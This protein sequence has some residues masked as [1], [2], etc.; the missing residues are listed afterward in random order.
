MPWKICLT[1]STNPPKKICF[2]LPVLLPKRRLPV[3]PPPDP[4][5]WLDDS[6]I[7]ETTFKDLATLNMI[8]VM[9]A[10]LT[11]AARKQVQGVVETNIKEVKLPAEY[12]LQFV[13]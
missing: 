2:Y 6:R 9:A 13:E 8:S 1:L 12:S 7:K 4:E 3:P 10:N 11:P 5:P